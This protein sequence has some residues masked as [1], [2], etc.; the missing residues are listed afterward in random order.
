[1]NGNSLGSTTYPDVSIGGSSNRAMIKL[2]GGSSSQ[3]GYLYY[4]DNTVGGAGINFKLTDATSNSSQ[5]FYF[6]PVNINT[7]P[8]GIYPKYAGSTHITQMEFPAYHEVRIVQRSVNDGS[9]YLRFYTDNYNGGSPID[10]E[11]LAIQG[12]S[13]T[14]ANAYFNNVNLGI[15]TTSATEVLDVNG[16]VKVN[17]IIGKTSAPTI[18]AGVGA[19]TSPTIAISGTDLSGNITITTGTLP[20]PSSTVATITFNTAYGVTPKTVLIT[21]ADLN[22][23]TICGANLFAAKSDIST[24]VFKLT[25]TLVAA[26]T[27]T[28]YYTIFQ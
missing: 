14:Y 12:S 2:G 16:N 23:A 27:Y 9:R 3:G 18:A 19:G 24:S 15:N 7:T 5:A 21:G 10:V 28:I 1:V 11:R 6:Y 8:F 13:G 20:T 26:T 4:L 25:G 17:H 22:G